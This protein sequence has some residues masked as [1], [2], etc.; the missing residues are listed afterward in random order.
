MTLKLSR[1]ERTCLLA[2]LETA[3]QRLCAESSEQDRRLLARVV[4]KLKRAAP[5]KR[6]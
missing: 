5:N 2:A 4:G 6:A 3:R 1:T